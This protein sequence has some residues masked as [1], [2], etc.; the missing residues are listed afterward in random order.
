M[1]PIRDNRHGKSVPS[2]T[3]T[4]IALNCI[5]FLWDR[6]GSLT[7]PSMVFSDL[8]MRPDQ[9]Y[10]AIRGRG[11]TFP[12]VTLFTSMFLH[13]NLLHLLGNMLYLLTFGST[14][15]QGMGSWRYSLYYLGWGFAASAA[16][17]F[18]DPHSPIPIVGASGAIGGVLG[19]YF[20]L[21]PG[22]KLE[23][24]IP[25][26]PVPVEAAAWVLLGSWFLF[27]IFFRQEGVANWAHAGGFLAGMLTILI[28]GGRA[29]VLA[30][31]NFEEDDEFS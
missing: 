26:V 15:E 13:G 19:S 27:Q 14:V 9:V 25:F 12:L 5:I 16:Q 7:N 30:G 6:S 20:L 2:V 21:F 11:E 31:K 1:L 18:V 29:K 22:N 28:M 24:I 17:I 10:R 23:I 8:A 3:Y 4:L